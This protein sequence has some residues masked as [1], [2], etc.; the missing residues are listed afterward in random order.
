MLEASG[1]R[2]K[3]LGT[4]NKTHLKDYQNATG[5]QTA[6]LLKVHRSNFKIT[7]FTAE[8]SRKDLISFASE[9]DLIYV[10]DLG[11]G[12]INETKLAGKAAEPG[13]KEIL[14]SG[15][16]L[17]TASGDKLLG[18]PQ[19]GLILGHRD[20]V[21][22]LR[23]HPLYRCLRCDKAQLYLLE[24]CL[25][26]YARGEA[27]LVP[28][29]RMLTEPLGDVE[30]RAKAILKG[31]DPSRFSLVPSRATP[32]GGALPEE[33]LDSWAIAIETADIKADLLAKKLRLQEPP[34]VARIEKDRLLVDAK[35]IQQH[36][37]EATQT[38]LQRLFKGG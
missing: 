14:A 4:T 20:L 16:P 35:C 5:P 9:N 22:K 11:S 31:L 28:T 15:A 17:V 21:E 23:S 25:L 7:G 29:Q 13:L 6:M 18:G 1:A 26:A 34:L 33:Y 24:Q 38:A 12:S 27:D 36:Q 2:L 8:P 37:I 3:E 19:A 32:G 30:D 10:E